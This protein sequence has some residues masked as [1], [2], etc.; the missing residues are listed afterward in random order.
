MHIN[1]ILVVH[2]TF[3]WMLF[4]IEVTILLG[5]MFQG[6]A[7]RSGSGGQCAAVLT[8]HVCCV[9][10]RGLPILEQHL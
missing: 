1:G 2:N 10:G 4:L 7:I 9:Q 3:L 8:A 5:A 6:R